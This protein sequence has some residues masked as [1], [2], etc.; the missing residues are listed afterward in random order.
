MNMHFH[1]RTPERTTDEPRPSKAVHVLSDEEDLRQALRRA[2]AF[3]QRVAEQL[4]TRSARYR[5]LL[6]EAV[7]TKD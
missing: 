7:S 3:D 6:G 2:A 5:A 4:S 1:R